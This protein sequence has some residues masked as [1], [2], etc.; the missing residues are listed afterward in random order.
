MNRITALEKIS[1]KVQKR[2]DAVRS[3]LGGEI[4][5]LRDD[6]K[7]LRERLRD[8]TKDGDECYEMLKDKH[9]HMQ[10]RLRKLRF[11]ISNDDF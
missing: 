4:Q 5:D 7:N 10:A 3:E 8:A 2:E 1:T 11:L 9:Q 6:V